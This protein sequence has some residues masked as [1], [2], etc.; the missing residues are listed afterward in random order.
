LSSEIQDHPYTQLTLDHHRSEHIGLLL[1]LQTRLDDES[2]YPQ[3][4]CSFCSDKLN[5]F[6]ELKEKALE[7]ERIV[8]KYQAEIEKHGLRHVMNSIEQEYPTITQ[9]NTW[10]NI[11]EKVKV[12]SERGFKC[13]TCDESFDVKL[14]LKLHMKTSHVKKIKC[15]LCNLVFKR[16]YSLMKHKRLIH[17]DLYSQCDIC[18]KRV[19][20]LSYHNRSAHQN[21]TF[22]CE[23]GKKYKSKNS[24]DYHKSTVHSAETKE[25]CQYCAAELSVKSLPLHIKLKHSGQV[26]RT[27]HCGNVQCTKLFRT[28]QQADTH[29]KASHLNVKYKCLYCE[30]E[31]KNIHSHVRQVHTNSKQ[32]TCHQCG[33]SF[34]KSHDLKLHR[35][36]IHQLKRYVCPV[37]GK[38]LSKIQE[39][40]KRIH[41]EKNI[42]MDS[43]QVVSSDELQHISEP[44]DVVTSRLISIPVGVKD[45]IMVLPAFFN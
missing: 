1:E 29:Y 17:E 43:I 37:C 38:K 28:K 32:H 3:F 2:L 12:K 45:E 34:S 31:F 7:S 36:R 14:S 30:G 20:D 6:L 19:K 40:M 5:D 24:L 23:C 21:I 35:E 11:D 16:K 42:K 39:H 25:V 22:D 8:L 15:D 4:I 41:G 27:V 33:K 26:E 10:E 18:D 9:D 13:E 44:Q